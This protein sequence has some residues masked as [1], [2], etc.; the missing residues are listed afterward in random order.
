MGERPSGRMSTM[1]A[2]RSRA[3][4]QP[5][6][7]M[8]YQSRRSADQQVPRGGG[9]AARASGRG[10]AGGRGGGAARGVTAKVLLKYWRLPHFK[11]LTLR[12]FIDYCHE[13]DIRLHLIYLSICFI[14]KERPVAASSA[15]GARSFCSEMGYGRVDRN[16]HHEETRPQIKERRRTSLDT[17]WTK[18]SDDEPRARKSR[19]AT[20]RIASGRGRPLICSS[21]PLCRWNI[22]GPVPAPRASPRARDGPSTTTR[23]RGLRAM[24]R[25][26]AS[27]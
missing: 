19:A 6:F 24:A 22:A 18:S 13:V 1:G 5:R 3:T 15:Y 8:V 23:D 11:V 9:E 10:D 12:R 25:L 2:R 16:E 27:P 20:G 26:Q 4:K 17:E 21:P 7:A 14:L